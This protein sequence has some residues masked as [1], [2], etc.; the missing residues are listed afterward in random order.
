MVL[1]LLINYILLLLFFVGVPCLVL[2]LFFS[3]LCPFSFE[4]ILMGEER[5]G[6]FTLFFS[7]VSCDCKCSM[8]LPHGAI[9]CSA[10][11]DCSIS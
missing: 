11:C 7:L 1:L 8:A 5:A 4:S 6:C 9:D 10:V 3:A 2:V